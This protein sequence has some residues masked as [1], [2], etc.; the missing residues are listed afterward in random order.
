MI[1]NNYQKNVIELAY[2]RH[3][4]FIKDNPEV[5]KCANKVLKEFHKEIGLWDKEED[6]DFI[7]ADDNEKYLVGKHLN[8]IWDDEKFK[9]TKNKFVRFMN[10]DKTKN[11]IKKMFILRKSHELDYTIPAQIYKLALFDYLKEYQIKGKKPWMYTLR[12]VNMIFPEVLTTISDRKTLFKTA[13][14]LQF[15]DIRDH[16]KYNRFELVQFKIRWAVNAL[17]QEKDALDDITLWGNAAVARNILD[18]YK[19]V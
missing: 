17:L 3:R 19:K 9:N 5:S 8:S 6:I 2:E 15:E 10:E 13:R 7:F 11:I 18:V 4:D 1:L 12:F 14:A 16:K